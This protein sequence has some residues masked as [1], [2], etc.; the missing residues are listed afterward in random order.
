L[1][2]LQA[3]FADAK[4]RIRQQDT[5]RG[6]FAPSPSGPLHFG[7]LIAALGSFLQARSQQGRW[8]VRIE[9]IDK[10]R[11]QPGAAT[12]IL[13]ALEAFGLHWDVDDY[14]ESLLSSDSRGCLVQ[15]QRLERYQ[16]IYQALLNANSVYGCECTR[17]QLK[18]RG[19]VYDGHCRL[20]G[21]PTDNNAVRIYLF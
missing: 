11:E 7:S 12:Q 4:T 17:K 19:G 14:T 13:D 2:P 3:L 6:R 18:A 10:P 15:S 9:D 1:T 21:L 8:F 5:Y 20:V 16:A